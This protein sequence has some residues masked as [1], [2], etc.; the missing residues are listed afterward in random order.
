MNF[1]CGSVFL[2]IVIVVLAL[3]SLT[4]CS[5]RRSRD[6]YKIGYSRQNAKLT[7]CNV[8]PE[9]NYGVDDGKPCKVTHLDVLGGTVVPFV[10]ECEAEG[11]CYRGWCCNF[12]Q[13]PL[14]V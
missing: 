11:Q 7:N 2:I 14:L 10:T 9:C 4:T 12:N 6:N 3:L 8:S 1:A 13:D 5:L